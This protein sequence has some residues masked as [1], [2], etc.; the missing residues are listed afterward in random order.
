MQDPQLCDCH[1]KAVAVGDIVRI[2]TL[3]PEFIADFPADERD[4]ITSMIGN[5]FKIYGIDEF[6]QPWV[7]K[8]WHDD[9][10]NPQTHVIALDPPEMERI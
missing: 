9:R 3:N 8:E 6:G 2:V 4:L 10:G 1:G 7:M 5:L